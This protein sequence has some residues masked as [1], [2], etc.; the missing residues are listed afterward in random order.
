MLYATHAEVNLAA[1]AH[2]V[3]QARSLAPGKKVLVALKAQAYGHGAVP[4][5]RHLVAEGLVDWFG[6]AT[7]PE[8]IEL[9]D[10]GID[11]P[12]LR[13]SHCF[14]EELDAAIAADITVP[15]VDA[16]TIDE[17]AR[18]ADR[19]GRSAYPV[20]LAIDTGMRRIGCEPRDAV[21]MAGL[22]AERGLDLQGLFTHLP[23]SDTPRGDEFTRA[24]LARF[25][26]AVR[27]VQQARADAGLAPVPLV[28][29]SN[30]GAV[31]GH[32]VPECTMVR[33]GIMV[34]GYY[35]DPEGTPRPVELQQA[36]TWKSRVSFVKRVLAGET[37]GYG[38]T[39]T[40]PE[41]SW[42]ATVPVGYGDGFSRLNSNRGRMLVG[43]A[44]YPVAGRVC[45]DQTMLDLGP[46][47]PGSQPP[48][49]VGDEVVVL[50]RQGDQAIGAD[51]LA[52]LMGTISYEVTC[53]INQ[54][55]ERVYRD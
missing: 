28:H 7:T 50:G 42:V 9:R 17:L 41:D 25:L 53:L 10:A 45:M 15:V 6:V 22:V 5:A 27:D 48:V 16:T 31:L 11:T 52:G 24:Q 2:N 46:A 37:V 47:T 32:P 18:A 21:A 49:K 12:I 23:I 51:E 26:A 34:Y 54:R 8:G 3:R 35:P 19:A 29:A 13:L 55:V 4:V 30:S 20:H 39:W 44:G 36:L 40:A 14:P 33:P 43:G 1:I 38:R